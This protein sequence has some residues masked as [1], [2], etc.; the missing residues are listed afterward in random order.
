MKVALHKHLCCVECRSDLELIP[1][2]TAEVELRSEEIEVI[3]ERRGN[4]SDYTTD[5]VEGYLDCCS[6][7]ARYQ[8]L[9]GI[10]RLYKGAEIKRTLKENKDEGFV[11][12][13]FNR[14]WDEF[15]YDDDRIWLWTRESRVDTFC[16]ELAIESAQQY[17]G[18]LMVD[19]GCGPAVLSM[20][21]SATYGIEIIA[22]DMSTVIDRATQINPSNLCH[23]IQCS[24]LSPPLKNGIADL[25]YSNGVLHHTYSTKNAFAAIEAITKPG[26]TLCVWLYGKK[27]GW[28]AFRFFFH[29]NIRRV[30]SRLPRY[31]QT[32]MVW[33]MAG[34]HLTV[35][36]FKRLLGMEKVQYKTM[37][38]FLVTMRDKYTPKYARE[39]REEEV[40]SWF[41]QHGYH[42]VERQ[43]D[44]I[45]TPLWQ[46]STDLSIRGTKDE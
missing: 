13:S 20:N 40:K 26:G 18:K 16:E 1:I 14:E 39:H 23:F 8:I 44:W 25:T 43:R 37:N 21:L 15:N 22:M 30:I 34:I 9:N 32:A 42:G 38:Q 29:R 19:C 2:S 4:V 28:L 41:E 6:C 46:G 24:V 7:D 10:P 12:R 36:F 3:S 17:N 27:Q 31:P 5:I 35:R 11:Q 33:V 45:K